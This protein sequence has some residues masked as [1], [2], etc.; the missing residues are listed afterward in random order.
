MSLNVTT[1]PRT[2]GLEQA[3]E[4]LQEEPVQDNRSDVE[5][6]STQLGGLP[7]EERPWGDE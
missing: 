2:A 7:R 5:G 3:D 1:Y 6:M 4:R